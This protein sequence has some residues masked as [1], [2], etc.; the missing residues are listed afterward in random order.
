[1]RPREHVAG[2]DAGA[3]WSVSLLGCFPSAFSCKARAFQGR[4]LTPLILQCYLGVRREAQQTR[5]ALDLLR[6][7]WDRE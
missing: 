4:F 6:A 7:Y 2:Q 5:P 1:M 3:L